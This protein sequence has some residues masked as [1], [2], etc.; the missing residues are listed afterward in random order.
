MTN[1]E[2]HR[3]FNGWRA[4]LVIDDTPVLWGAL[5]HTYDEAAT[6]MRRILA[7]LNW[8]PAP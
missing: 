6:S 1:V 5:H 8:V 3:T 7:R 4:V 2:I